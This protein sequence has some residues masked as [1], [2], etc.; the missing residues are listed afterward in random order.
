MFPIFEDDDHFE[1][2]V[3]SPKRKLKKKK[4]KKRKVHK[5]RLTEK[6]KKQRRKEQM[7]KDRDQQYKMYGDDLSEAG[8]WNMGMSMHNVHRGD[9]ESFDMDHARD[10]MD[11]LDHD[12]KVQLVE[13]KKQRTADRGVFC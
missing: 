9:E 5:E 8:T 3:D 11:E 2:V 1:Y 6:E 10:L 4:S 7:R 13:F 12:A